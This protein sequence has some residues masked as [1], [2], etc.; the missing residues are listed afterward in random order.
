[1]ISKL[2]SSLSSLISDFFQKFINK[3]AMKKKRKQFSPLIEKLS[4]ILD[5]EHP[6]ITNDDYAQYLLNKDHP[7]RRR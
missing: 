4:G 3:Y 1:M 6:N 2:T 7:L 5:L